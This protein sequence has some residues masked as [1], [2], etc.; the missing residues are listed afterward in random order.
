[1]LRTCAS[2]FGAV[3]LSALLADKAFSVPA[4][5]V[6]AAAEAGLPAGGGTHHA[7]RA[8][9]V[10]FLY[11]DG[12]VSQVDSF[13][14]K[15]RLTRDD[16]K[17]FAMKTEPTQFDNIGMTLG[18]PWEFRNYGECGLPVSDLFPKTAAHADDLCVVR[19]MVSNFSE[20][21][22]ANYFLHSGAGIAGRPSM[23]SWITYGLGSENA[24]LPGYVV[25][26]GGL[27]PSGGPDNFGSGFLPAS[28]QASMMR[29]SGQPLANID[30]TEPSEKIQRNKLALMEGLD[31]AAMDRMGRL[32]AMESALAN[33]ELAFRMQASVPEVASIEGESDAVKKLYGMD[34]DFEPTRI[35]AR[36][37]IIAR[38]LIERGVRFIEL[39][40]PR[41]AGNDRWDAHGG[42]RKNHSENAMA[43]DQPIAGLLHDL[44]TT[45]LLDE[46][47]VVW[48]G[49]F[50]R[51]PFAQGRDGRDHNP[52]GFTVWLAGGGIRGGMTYGATDEFGY[53]VVERKVE[54]HDLHAS[55]LHLLGV[56]HTRQ[57]FRYGGRDM[58]L[59]DVH[60]HVMHDWFA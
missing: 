3:A 45:G 21:N 23:G 19:S 34:S 8:K 51:T 52:Y 18:A 39:T 31:N 59:T 27:M 9:N 40:C 17:P 48:A 30:R 2:G 56:D 53:K 58:R 47:L 46:T 15:P 29:P 49:E 42:L 35:Y 25:L 1:M 6:R 11:M 36:E 32:D 44:K 10:I 55:M 38:R 5:L 54:I 20:H 37:C 50:G 41:T 33:Y 7:P 26:N 4:E 14:P 12:G 28:Y 16:G 24:N 22:A 57:T 60:G 13:D 43:T